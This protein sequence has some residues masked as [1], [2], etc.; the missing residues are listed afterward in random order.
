MPQTKVLVD[1]NSYLRLAQS[2][3]PLLFVEFGSACHCLYVLPELEKEFSRS[4]R[5]QTKFA[6]AAEEEY[7]RNRQTYLHVSR[8]Q[9]VAIDTAMSFI[10]NYVQSNCPGPSKVDVLH[11]AYGYELQVPVVTDDQDLRTA[12][13]AL[14]ITTWCSLELLKLMVDAAH[15]PLSKVHG[16]VQFWRYWRD[17]PANL[18][19]DYKRLFGV[20][21]P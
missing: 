11:L 19:A 10:W 21:P 1:T 17:P 9:K 13:S 18:V 16:L 6:W 20:D 5:L 8:K 3:H 15:V 7:R 2:I 14:G 4:P 12:G